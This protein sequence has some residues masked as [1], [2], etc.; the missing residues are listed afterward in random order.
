MKVIVTG[1]SGQLGREVVKHLLARGHQVVAI[2]HSREPLNMHGVKWVRLD[3]SNGYLFEDLVWKEKPHTIIHCAAM[4]DVDACEVDKPRA[5]RVNVE[6]TRSVVRAARAVNAHIIYVSTDYVFDGEKGMYKEADT[7]S[8]INFYGLTKLIGEELVKSSDVLYTIIRPSAIF[9]SSAGKKGFAEYV[10][11]R[12]STGQ[13]VRAL[14]DQY[15]SPTYNVFL[16]EAIV[17]IAEIKPLGVLHVAGDR[18]SRYEFA[19]KIAEALEAPKTLVK[20]ARTQEMSWTA[21]RPRDSSLDTS[22]ARAL[23]GEFHDT[24]KAIK[25]FVEESMRSK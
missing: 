20:E 15:V 12:L 6:A 7:P 8:P 22:K 13:E 3:L 19:L 21:R 10:V 25:L 2:H 24:E 17:K 9:G 18:M 11:E 23:L 16:G 4:T 5:W 14:V 1:G